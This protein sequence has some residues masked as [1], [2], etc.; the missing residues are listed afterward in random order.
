[1]RQDW[2]HIYEKMALGHMDEKHKSLHEHSIFRDSV[3]P[4]VVIFGTKNE[5]LPGGTRFNK[6][7]QNL[8]I[9]QN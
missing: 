3:C 7:R 2:T 9:L 8:N 5:V 1:M 6:R 4:E